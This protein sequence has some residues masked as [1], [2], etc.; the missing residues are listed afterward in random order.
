[1][2]QFIKAVEIWVPGS[3]NKVLE[4]GSAYYGELGDFKSI[5]ESMSFA[6]D[7]GLPGKTW[8]TG[9]AIVLTD[10]N[11]NSYFQ[12]AEAANQASIDCGISIPVFC[13][14]F[15]QA[16]VILFCGGSEDVKGAMEVWHNTNGSNNEL[17]LV[18][19][20]YGELEKFEWVSRRLTIMRGRGLPG[21]AWDQAR[22]VIMHDL[23][24]SST[25]LRASHAADAGIT[26]GLAIP[27]NL[28]APDIEILTL[29][30]AEGT[31]IARRFEI[32]TPNADGTFL[33]FDSGQCESADDLGQRYADTLIKKGEGPI[34]EAWLTGRPLVADIN[35]D[36][37]NAMFVLP[38]IKGCTLNSMVCLVL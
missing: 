15:L 6:F 5:S 19:G 10:I 11:N 13:G 36:A 2:K 7:E 26:T 23:G 9:R 29:L 4:L 33:Q 20:Y 18:D 37:G 28:V 16:V 21:S 25:F 3:K 32:W 1:M 22:P 27:I 35:P 30:S 24:S 12:R 31:P 14:E 34:G 17:S 38:V 8:S